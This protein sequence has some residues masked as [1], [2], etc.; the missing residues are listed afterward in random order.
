MAA[1]HATLAACHCCGLVQELPPLSSGSR[2]RCSRCSAVVADPTRRARSNARAVSAALAAL[3][4]YPLAIS[5]PIMRIERFGHE[6]ESSIWAGAWELL[7]EGE[8]LVASVVLTCSIVIPLFKLIG[9]LAITLGRGM[10]SRRH[11]ALTYRLIEWTG[12][13]GMLDV[14]LIAI[15]VAWIKIGDL[16]QVTPGPAA[17]AFT[18][19]VLL[20]LLASAWF[21]PHAV[22]EGEEVAL[23]DPQT[24]P[25]T[26][27]GAPPPRP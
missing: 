4:L 9:M 24:D 19:V 27:P 3:L 18:L 11:R 12:R 22:W 20:S 16:V 7:F 8:V 6:R 26:D 25:Q 15:L 23:A 13:W 21:D 14:L 1:R 5:L 17:L 2:A 10:L